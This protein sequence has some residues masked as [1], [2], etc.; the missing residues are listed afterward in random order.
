MIDIGRI[1]LPAF[2]KLANWL[3]KFA[4]W[5]ERL[6]DSIKTAGVAVVG[7]ATVAI[8]LLVASLWAVNTA[9]LAIVANPVGLAI[10][11][12]GTAIVGLTALVVALVSR[13]REANVE[14]TELN[15]DELR[16]RELELGME[17]IDVE[18]QISAHEAR[19]GRDPNP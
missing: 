14:L 11:G 13:L 6:P 12:I 16:K 15:L 9:L 4:E 17:L 8:P 7:I 1:V 3:G 19:G 2:D 5:F 18:A 10:V